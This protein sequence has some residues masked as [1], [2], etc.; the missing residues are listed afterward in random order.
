MSFQSDL[1]KWKDK[2]G[3]QAAIQE[4]GGV[5]K[6][7]ADLCTDILTYAKGFSKNTHKRIAVMGQTSYLWMCNAYGAIA[8]GKTV[9]AVDP[10]LPA[11]D[12]VILMKNM[13]AE[14]VF[15]DIEDRKLQKAIE[16]AGI[17]YESYLQEEQLQGGILQEETENGDIIVFTSGTSGKAKGVVVPFSD[18]CNNAKVLMEDIAPGVEGN[19]YTPLP[20]YHMY[21]TVGILAFLYKGR[22]VY[23]GN[24]RRIME[25]L[26]YFKP[27]VMVV[28][29]AMAEFLMKNNAVGDW[30]KVFTV[31]GAK[32]DKSLELKCTEYG[33]KLQNIY[34]ASEIAGVIAV[35]KPEHGIE[36]L[37]A[38]KGVKVTVE[39]ENEIAIEAP[40][41]LKEYYKNPEA[42]ADVMRNG[43]IYLGDIGEAFEDGTFS[44][45]GRKKDV[46]AM[47]NGNK[48]YCDE[49]DEELTAI[50]G[51]KEACVIYAEGKVIAVVVCEEGADEAVVKKN[52]KQYN[53]KQ[54]YFRK[55]DGIW[56]RKEPLP[57]AGLG[58]LKRNVVMDEYS[59]SKGEV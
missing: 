3:S 27:A 30:G 36:K 57:R 32:C 56:M 15:T 25:E 55:M 46:I 8:A 26:V 49:M 23:L 24:P 58:K 44:P 54:P 35:N 34:G 33:I 12:I 5:S 48:L 10:L 22:T 11:D 16:E 37:T 7:Y 14:A 41:H 1:Q 29:S 40:F 4:M 18:V 50:A 2:F 38:L 47:S 43:K 31:A 45:M 9:I 59:F 6:S 51:V 39:E 19:M 21:A 28:V 42:T 17:A 53:K 20:L 52:L 13:D